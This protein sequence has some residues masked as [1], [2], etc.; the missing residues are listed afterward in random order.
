MKKIISSSKLASNVALS[1]Q[2]QEIKKTIKKQAKKI[3]EQDNGL[4][5][6]EDFIKFMKKQPSFS[7][8]P[9]VDLALFN[10]QSQ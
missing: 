5:V 6:V 7:L 2:N 3:E 9:S 10:S 1:Q 8:T 4:H